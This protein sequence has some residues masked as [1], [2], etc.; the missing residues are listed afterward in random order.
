M[1][2]AKE[3]N[4]DKRTVPEKDSSQTIIH[5]IRTYVQRCNTL[6]SFPGLPEAYMLAFTLA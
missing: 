3:R 5:K 1:D 4:G 2:E 6:N